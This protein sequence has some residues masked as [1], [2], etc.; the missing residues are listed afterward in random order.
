MSPEKGEEEIV[1]LDEEFLTSLLSQ[2]SGDPVI[3]FNS[4]CSIPI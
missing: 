2:L 3:W 4:F 1:E